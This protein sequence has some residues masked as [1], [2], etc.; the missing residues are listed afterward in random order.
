MAATRAANSAALWRDRIAVEAYEGREAAIA[1]MCDYACAVTDRLLVTLLKD[2]AKLDADFVREAY[3][4]AKTDALGAIPFN[5]VMIA[6]F[7][8]VGMDLSFRAIR[9]LDSHQLDWEQAMVVI[10]GKAGRPT[11]GVTWTSNSIAQVILAASGRRL[12]LDRLYIAPHAD[13]FVS[14]GPDDI[15]PARE[16]EVTFRWLWAF[17]RAISELA[18]SMYAGYPSYA[19]RDSRGPPITEDT[20]HLGEMPV[21]SGPDDMLAMTTRLRMVLEDPR[22]LLSGAVTDYAAEQLR[23]NGNDC[24]KIVVPG[25][26]N[27]DYW[28]AI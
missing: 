4:E 9:W 1:A 25:L 5:T 12:P 15:E 19:A 17:T 3:L 20:L 28:K 23:S 11:S 21:I 18:P 8:L 6:T 22:Q 13:T 16:K 14:L 24:S 10:V 2:E 7:F 27:C 26:D